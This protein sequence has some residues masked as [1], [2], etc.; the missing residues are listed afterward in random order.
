MSVNPCSAWLLRLV[1]RQFLRRLEADGAIVTVNTPVRPYQKKAVAIGRCLSVPLS[2]GFVVLLSA[3]VLLAYFAVEPANARQDFSFHVARLSPS[4]WPTKGPRPFRR[5]LDAA[6]GG[7]GECDRKADPRRPLCQ[8]GNDVATLPDSATSWASVR[9]LETEPVRNID[10][11]NSS[12]SMVRSTLLAPSNPTI[13]SPSSPTSGL[14]SQLPSFQ[15]WTWFIV[16]AILTLGAPFAVVL[17]FFGL[18]AVLV[19]C[20]SLCFDLSWQLQLIAFAVLGIISALLWQRL[21]RLLSDRN[22][23]I[24]RCP[25]ALVGRVFRLQSPIVD[26]IGAV[27]IGGTLWRVAGRNC[28]AGEQVKVIDAEGTL[29]IV[30]PLEA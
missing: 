20:I 21:D 3:A 9:P 29:L 15:G 22:D 2:V 1:A 28:A 24:G 18:A 16:A 13:V 17:C 14:S 12:T 7:N 30:D 27:T 5:R 8:F 4:D 6:P 10:G 23:L 25:H 26:G 11:S 19:G